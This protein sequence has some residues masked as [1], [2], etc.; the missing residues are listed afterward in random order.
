MGLEHFSAT[1]LTKKMLRPLRGEEAELLRQHR[2][3]AVKKQRARP[4][5]LPSTEAPTP[6]LVSHTFYAEHLGQQWHPQ[7]ADQCCNIGLMQNT[8]TLSRQFQGRDKRS[9]NN[10]FPGNKQREKNSRLADLCVQRSQRATGDRRCVE[11]GSQNKDFDQARLL[12]QRTL[13]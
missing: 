12:D 11:T 9:N 8:D 3:G 1:I 5:T 7:P 4:P 13:F 10:G 2:V 6:P